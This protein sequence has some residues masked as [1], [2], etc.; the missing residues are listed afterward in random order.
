MLL[1]AMLS[2]NQYA[3]DLSKQENK[4]INCI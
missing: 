1:R 3:Y 4:D 2:A